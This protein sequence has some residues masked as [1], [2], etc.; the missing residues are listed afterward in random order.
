MSFPLIYSLTTATTTTKQ[1]GPFSHW[2]WEV[3]TKHLKPKDLIKQSF[4]MQFYLNRWTLFCSWVLQVF[5][6]LYHYTNDFLSCAMSSTN[7]LLIHLIRIL[8]DELQQTWLQQIKMLLL[9][10]TGR[11][12]RWHLCTNRTTR[13]SLPS[14]SL[15]RWQDVQFPCSS[16]P[17]DIGILALSRAPYTVNFKYCF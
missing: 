12:H 17:S 5:E 11:R 1:P 8:T 3:T 10:A 16:N 7:F 13:E 9:S 6:T 2:W 14:P 4:K 15:W